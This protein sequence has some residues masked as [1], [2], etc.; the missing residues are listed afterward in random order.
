MEWEGDQ[1]QQFAQPVRSEAT[2]EAE[3]LFEILSKDKQ[4]RTIWDLQRLTS[5]LIRNKIFVRLEQKYGNK[6]MFQVFKQLRLKRKDPAKVLL[7]QGQSKGHFYYIISGA[8]ACYNREHEEPIRVLGAAQTLGEEHVLDNYV[9]SNVTYRVHGDDEAVLAKLDLLELCEIIF[10]IDSTFL[11]SEISFLRNFRVLEPLTKMHVAKIAFSLEVSYFQRGQVAISERARNQIFF[12]KKGTLRKHDVLFD[13]CQVLGVQLCAQNAKFSGDF[14]VESET[15]ELFRLDAKVFFQFLPKAGCILIPT[16]KLQFGLEK[17][18]TPLPHQLQNV[19][20]KDQLQ[21]YKP[22][23]LPKY[24][25]L[26]QKPTSLENSYLQ[27]NSGTFSA[28]HSSPA[29]S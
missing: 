1:F 6:I 28:L 25:N 19:V 5:I 18:S 10:N 9:Q 27:Q 20:I 12:L 16:H 15:C 23:R 24:T 8:V 4:M 29:P 14:Q 22:P 2:E 11:H 3:S 17:S 21:N 7:R 13:A 26:L